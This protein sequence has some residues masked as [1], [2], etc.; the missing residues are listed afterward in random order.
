MLRRRGHVAA[1]T[2]FDGAGAGHAW[3]RLP[4][5]AAPARAGAPRRVGKEPLSDRR[6]EPLRRRDVPRRARVVP[7]PGADRVRRRCSNANATADATPSSVICSHAPS[8]VDAELHAYQDERLRDIVRHAYDTV[9][10]Y[11]RRFDEHK[12]SR[13]TSAAAPTCRS[14]RSSPATT[15]APISTRCDRPPSAPRACGRAT[16]AA[17]P[18]RR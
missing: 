2:D 10:F 13:R 17:P 16:P 18:G 7:E 5:L 11:R 4:D 3:R 15:S 9:P 8:G 1:G 6:H 12:L 14:C